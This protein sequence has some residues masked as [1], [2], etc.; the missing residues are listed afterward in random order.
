MTREEIIQRLTQTV[1]TMR[2]LRIIQMFFL[3]LQ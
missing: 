2:R 3:T 1:K